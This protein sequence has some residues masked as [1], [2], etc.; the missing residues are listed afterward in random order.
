MFSGKSIISGNLH[1]GKGLDFLG[2]VDNFYYA[3]E[4]IYIPNL[5]GNLKGTVKAEGNITL[6]GDGVNTISGGIFAKKD[7]LIEDTWS[8]AGKIE[9]C[10]IADY[11]FIRNIEEISYVRNY[12]RTVLR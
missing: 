7:C 3:K 4:D 11:L 12:A 1:L 6:K 2:P 10:V 8:T 5:H 9:G